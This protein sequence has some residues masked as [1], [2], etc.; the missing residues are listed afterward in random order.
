MEPAI[1]LLR[2]NNLAL[3]LAAI[4]NGDYPMG[5]HLLDATYG[6]IKPTQTGNSDYYIDMEKNEA[7]LFRTTVNHA[8]RRERG[9]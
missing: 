5:F 6:K 4:K 9:R 1:R 8:W 7:E 3:A 2:A